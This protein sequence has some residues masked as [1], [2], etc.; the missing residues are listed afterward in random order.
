[1]DPL[2][3][4]YTV[5]EVVLSG[6]DFPAGISLAVLC[7]PEFALVFAK[8]SFA[9]LKVLNCWAFSIWRKSKST[10]REHVNYMR[11]RFALPLPR[12][13]SASHAT[14]ELRPLSHLSHSKICTVLI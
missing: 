10:I 3:Q 6:V 5:F 4:F 7:V 11:Q 2:A 12:V 14:R 9:K 1:M 8:E 13:S